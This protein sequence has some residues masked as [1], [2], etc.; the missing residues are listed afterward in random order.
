[1]KKKFV[2][3]GIIVIAIIVAAA[4]VYFSQPE[5]I[6]SD[7]NRYTIARVEYNGVDVTG[8]VD[9][10]ALASI[11]SK[12]KCSRLP[13]SFSPYQQSQV[14]VELNGLNGNNPLHILLGDINVAY[15]SANN[16]GFSILDSGALLTEIRNFLPNQ[17][18]EELGLKEKKFITFSDG[19]SAD[20]WRPEH[21]SSDTYKLSDGTALLTITDTVGPGNVHVGGVE[22][23]EVLSASAQKAV[24]AFYKEQGL[25]YDTQLELENAYTEYLSCKKKRNGI[26]GSLHQP[27][28]RPNGFQ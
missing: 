6:V 16:G 19:E 22:G 28:Y 9:C 18:Q 12:Y 24:S 23:L 8:R 3:T 5:N 25:L 26:P 11:V 15:Q 21:S 14:V 10:K 7:V 13:R 27:G 2:I 17:T 20:L 4:I 1:M